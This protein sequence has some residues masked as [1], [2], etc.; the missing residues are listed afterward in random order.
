MKLAFRIGNDPLTYLIDI[1]VEN[2]PKRDL[3]SAREIFEQEVK[4][5]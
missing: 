5:R 1:D 4:R 2:P 3:R